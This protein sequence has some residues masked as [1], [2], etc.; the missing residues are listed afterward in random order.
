L[1]TGQVYLSRREWLKAEEDLTVY[2]RDHVK[3]ESGFF[4]R[5]L[6]RFNQE[7]Y[8]EAIADWQKCLDLGPARADECRQRIAEA[9]RRLNP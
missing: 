7:K 8:R 9:Q 4:A 3:G 2:L 5:G 1:N 6:A